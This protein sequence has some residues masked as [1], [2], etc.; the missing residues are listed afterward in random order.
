MKVYLAWVGS[1]SDARVIG[2]YSSKAD[3][4][5]VAKAIDDSYVDEFTLD[6]GP[7]PP[8]E[9][10]LVL[11]QVESDWTSL[12]VHDANK[13][14]C[15][16]SD[17]YEIGVA[18]PMYGTQQKGTVPP[19]PLAVY[20]YARDEAHATKIAADKFREFVALHQPEQREPKP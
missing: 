16:Y 9:A 15:Y 3:A 14:G 2:V 6:A 13:V 20:V 17:E 12:N 4:E 1:Y 19:L 10:G 7:K 8:A 11:W 18:R 5:A